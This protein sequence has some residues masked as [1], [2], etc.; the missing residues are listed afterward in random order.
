MVKVPNALVS[1]GLRIVWLA[2]EDR[3]GHRIEMLAGNDFVP[4]LESIE[5]TATDWPSSPPLAQW[6]CEKRPGLV[7]VALGVGRA[8]TSHWSASIEVVSEEKW[9]EQGTGLFIDDAQ[10]NPDDNGPL[11]FS[12]RIAFD[13]ACRACER[14]MRL[15]SRYRCLGRC[16]QIDPMRI[17]L[18][19]GA[20]LSC[21]AETTRLALN[22]A[23]GIVAIEPLPIT[24]IEWPQTIRWRYW[25]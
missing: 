9:G 7:R 19:P 24:A 18:S 2:R 8:G 10:G 22:A 20:F 1:A 5:S 11:P 4:L 17:E 14:P 12:A 13:L 21:D 16:R 23:T 25:I 3:A 15:G 6:H